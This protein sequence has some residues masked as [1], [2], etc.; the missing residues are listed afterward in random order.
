MNNSQDPF[1]NF[2][3][4]GAAKSGTTALHEILKRH[5]RL[6]LPRIKETNFFALAGEQVDFQGPLDDYTINRFSIT[7]WEEYQAQFAT[8]N[9]AL[10]G[11][12]CPLY[13]YSP[14][15]SQEIARRVPNA[16]IIIILRNPVDRAYSNYL[17]LVRDGRETL[18]FFEALG[19][20]EERISMNWEWFW[21]IKRQGYYS[22]QVQRYLDTFPAHQVKVF[23]YEHFFSEAQ[24]G[25][26]EMLEFIGLDGKD[27]GPVSARYNVSGRPVH[28]VRPIYDLLMRPGLINHSLRAVLPELLRKNLSSGFKRLV[29]R[30]ESMDDEIREKLYQEYA[31]DIDTLEGIIGQ[32]LS[33][34]RPTTTK[35]ERS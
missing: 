1:V 23:I 22:A 28:W 21:H 13:L 12:V 6:C 16:R 2:L 25:L 31:R 15:A 19:Q 11:E 10:K 20:E 14:K 9:S 4:V 32:S 34:W 5:P 26:R 24:N 33:V 29:V 8:S 30:H 35:D 3:V 7:D 17:H 27:A 18:S